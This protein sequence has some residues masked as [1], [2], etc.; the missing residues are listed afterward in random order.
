MPP[1]AIGLELFLQS[2]S[3]PRVPR[4]GLGHSS[5]SSSLLHHLLSAVASPST[6]RS[7]AK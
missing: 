4:G 6:T 1:T 3:L 7:W 5:F 2:I